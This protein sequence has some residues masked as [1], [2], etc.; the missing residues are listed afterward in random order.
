[1]FASIRRH[2]KWLL[3]VIIGVVIISFVIFFT[4][5]IGNSRAGS[6]MGDEI[7]SVYGRPVTRDQLSKAAT[8]AR[9]VHRLRSRDWSQGD[10]KSLEQDA[11][12]R[13][14]VLEKVKEMKIHVS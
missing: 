14:V 5:E 11:L 9:F 8:D 6:G 4:P 7:G 12:Q 10:D 1:M 13:L 2:Q 3:S